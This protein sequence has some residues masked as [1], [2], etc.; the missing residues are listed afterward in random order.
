MQKED[1]SKK[2]N[3]ES[4]KKS[5]LKWQQS[6]QISYNNKYNNSSTLNIDTSLKLSSDDGMTLHNFQTL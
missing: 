3:K 1:I 6:C 5:E 4:R 2:R